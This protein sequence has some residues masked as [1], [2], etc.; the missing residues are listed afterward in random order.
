MKL[1]TKSKLNSIINRLWDRVKQRFDNTFKD[2][3]LDNRTLKFTKANDSSTTSD[4]VLTNFAKTDEVTNF[5]NKLSA[6]VGAIEDYYHIGT[7]RIDTSDNRICGYRGITS[8]S[9]QD[10][11]VTELIV[12]LGNN[13]GDNVNLKVWAM[14]KASNRTDDRLNRQVQNRSVPV[15]TIMEGN[16]ERKC[17]RVPINNNFEGNEVYFLVKTDRGK[18]LHTHATISQEYHNDSVN[19]SSEPRP[20]TAL[21]WNANATQNVGI[22]LLVGRESIGS[23]SEK[24]KTLYSSITRLESLLN[25]N[26]SNRADN[27]MEENTNITEQE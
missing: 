22:M 11:Y 13:V 15:T 4:V 2:V 23:L 18:P 17:A 7:S 16:V 9:F 14:N 26:P 6:N 27:T 25:Q 10:N 1:V 21:E 8:K 3:R 5:E 24:V 19:L 20:G 12:L